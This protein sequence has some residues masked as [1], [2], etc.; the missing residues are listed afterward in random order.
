MVKREDNVAQVFVELILEATDENDLSNKS[1]AIVDMLKAINIEKSPSPYDSLTKYIFNHEIKN[2][3][4]VIAFFDVSQ[5]IFE[6]AVS[7]DSDD[8]QNIE[9]FFNS[10]RRHI[11]LAVIQQVYIKKNSIEAFRIS[12]KA[13]KKI[14]IL[15]SQIEV[16]QADLEKAGLEI[17]KMEKVKGSIY[18]EFIAILGIF[19]ALIFGLFGGFD[20]LSKAIVSISNEWSMGRVLIIS[21]GIMLCLTLLIFGLLQWVA[22]ITDRKLTSCDCYKKGSECNHSL[23]QRH[24]TLFSLVLSFIFV[25]LIG[26]YIESYENITGIDSF[27]KVHPWMFTKLAWGIPIFS[28]SLIL[29]ILFQ[30]F[31]KP[32][33]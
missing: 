30:I 17:E 33:K 24:R 4:E 2:A 10:I 12:E 27:Q 29:F 16:A 7:L 19:S 25:F 9:V 31:K 13:E 32:K 14:N 5:E 22:R 1:K 18:T 11:K 28:S 21:S 3:D 6:N 20:G 23:F 15:E 8:Y 26:E